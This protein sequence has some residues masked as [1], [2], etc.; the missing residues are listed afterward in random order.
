M[1][2]YLYLNICIIVVLYIVNKIMNNISIVPKYSFVRYISSPLEN[3]WL[4]YLYI[5]TNNYSYL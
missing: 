5:Y 3:E 4:K 1:L 2:V